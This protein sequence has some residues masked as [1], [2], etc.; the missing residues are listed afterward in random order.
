MEP[1]VEGAVGQKL[2][3]VLLA[4]MPADVMH[5]RLAAKGAGAAAAALEALTVSFDAGERVRARTARHAL[6]MIA[7]RRRL[8]AADTRIAAKSELTG[9][10]FYGDYYRWG[11][12][13][14]LADVFWENGRTFRHDFASLRR[15]FGE[16]AVAVTRGLS[17]Q[18]PGSPGRGTVSTM[19]F[20]DYVDEITGERP[21]DVYLTSSNGA[22]LGPLGALLDE[23]DVVPSIL[24]RSLQ[25][26]HNTFLFIGPPGAVTRAH[27]DPAN[28]LI[29][30]MLGTKR[31]RLFAPW[32][33]EFLYD[34]PDH[35][36]AADVRDPDPVRHPLV[37]L[38]VE[39]SV[40]LEPGSALF[41]PAGWWHQVESETP[42]LS[43]TLSSFREPNRALNRVT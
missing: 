42:S 36:S 18:A 7:V 19:R 8:H 3:D 20:A 10:R 29:V 34:L 5:V 40:T 30:Q 13:V 26:V 38:A 32:D 28:V 21:G 37:R 23:I 6:W 43:F 39:R 9:D 35:R 2:R 33:S 24:D 31:L 4:G 12:P 41:V 14:K 16:H 25:T 1:N 22:M 27:Y 17:A 15:D 11:R